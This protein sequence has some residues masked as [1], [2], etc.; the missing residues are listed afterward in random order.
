M[1]RIAPINIRANFVTIHY[2]HYFFYQ[3]SFLYRGVMIAALNSALFHFKFSLLI[4]FIVIKTS[5]HGAV[6]KKINK[7]FNLAI[8]LLFSVDL[9]VEQAHQG[10][11]F[12][13]GQCCTAGSR[14]YVEEPIYEEFVRRSVE[15]AKRRIVG[16]PFD[17][18]TQQGPQVRED[19]TAITL[20]H[21]TVVLFNHLQ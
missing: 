7:W 18:T 6:L 21:Y 11:F 12:N 1:Y 2:T 17:P 14:I 4:S 8:D 5:Y 13:A 3:M 16:S 10:V 15:R 20:L 9:A 19:N